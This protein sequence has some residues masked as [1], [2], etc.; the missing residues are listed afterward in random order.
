MLPCIVIL[1]ILLLYQLLIFNLTTQLRNLC[2]IYQFIFYSY[3]F[4]HLLT[5]ILEDS[6]DI[7]KPESSM[8]HHLARLKCNYATL[9]ERDPTHQHC[10][11]VY[12]T[13]KKG[14]NL[15]KKGLMT[16]LLYLHVSDILSLS[17]S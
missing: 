8:F 7:I 1:N 5:V 10:S 14:S 3:G 17:C 2:H 9:W 4:Y 13:I 11:I 16:G 12:T 15:S 6:V